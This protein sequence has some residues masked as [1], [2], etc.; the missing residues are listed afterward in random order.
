MIDYKT[1]RI[2][3]NCNNYCLSTEK[4]YFRIYLSDR[5]D[6]L[7][8]QRKKLI[9]EIKP[10]SFNLELFHKYPHKKTPKVY[11]STFGVFFI[12]NPI[13]FLITFR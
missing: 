6:P 1:E 13:Y 5:K 8:V 4:I 2:I 12:F 3:C 11:R 7:F 10:A 9:S